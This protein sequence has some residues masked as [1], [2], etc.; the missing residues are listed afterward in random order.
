MESNNEQAYESVR[1]RF[2]DDIADRLAGVA[3]A[4]EGKTLNYSDFPMVDFFAAAVDGFPGA[5]QLQERDI[6]T[7]YNSEDFGLEPGR[8]IL[9]G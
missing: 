7:G 1:A 3:A 4:L 9:S 2:G 8:P 5:T 6:G